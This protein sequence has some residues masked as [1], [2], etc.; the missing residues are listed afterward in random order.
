MIRRRAHAKVNL[1]LA[2]APPE[3]PGGP[4]A[5]WHRIRTWIHAI[6]L[7][8]EVAVAALP[9]GGVSTWS[10]RWDPAAPRPGFTDWPP[11]RD[12]AWRALRALERHV[13]R[14][15]PTRIVITK[16]IPT[17]AGLGGGSADAAGAL[18]AIDE[19]WDLRLGE[20]ALREIGLSL[21]SDVPFFIDD[22]GISPPRPALIGGFGGEIERVEPAA[23]E[24]LLLLPGFG[25]PT[26]AVYRAFD[27]L[28]AGRDHR[29]REREVRKMAGAG[30]TGSLFNDLAPAA[31]A[32]RPALARLRAAAQRSLGRPVH[33]TG[34][35]STLFVLCEPG[36]S[37]GMA[38]RARASLPGLTPVATRLI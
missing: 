7:F 36:E 20:P 29:I 33:V 13:G 22:G 37:A 30:P 25:C 38:D 31:E 5:G 28:I 26:G 27:G 9:E 2:L 11:A 14:P 12:L 16:R 24:L 10:V 18:L 1:A 15:L 21:G 6:D 32:A 35:G 17:G 23:S 19:A 3:P 34:S 4:R 8:D